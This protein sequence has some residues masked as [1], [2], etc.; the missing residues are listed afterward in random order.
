MDDDEGREEI[1][2]FTR[3]VKEVVVKCING[4]HIIKKNNAQEH[5]QKAKYHA[6][7][8]RRLKERDDGN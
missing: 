4:S 2:K 3:K 8:T 1:T 6:D 5:I 7:A